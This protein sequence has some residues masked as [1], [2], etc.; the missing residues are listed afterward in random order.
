MGIKIIAPAHQKREGGLVDLLIVDKLKGK[1][2]QTVDNVF[3]LQ[4]TENNDRVLQI[5]PTAGVLVKLT[6]KP[7]LYENIK[8]ELQNPTWEDIVEVLGNA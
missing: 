5:K 7:S 3:Y 4:A 6:T 2:N 1:I 8:T